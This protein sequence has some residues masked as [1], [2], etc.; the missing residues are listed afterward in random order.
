M[1]GGWRAPIAVR[2]KVS[3][4]GNKNG[5]AS[6]D[7]EADQ[8]SIPAQLHCGGRRNARVFWGDCRNQAWA[9]HSDFFNTHA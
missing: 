2:W 3:I 6:F 7:Q 5:S 4:R 9:N 8:T 1:A